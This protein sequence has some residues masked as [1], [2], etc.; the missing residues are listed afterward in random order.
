MRRGRAVIDVFPVVDDL[1]RAAAERFVSA[2]AEASGRSGRFAVALSATA[3]SS[4]APTSSSA[5][6]R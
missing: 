5:S 6:G 4:G 2:A 1:M 3:I